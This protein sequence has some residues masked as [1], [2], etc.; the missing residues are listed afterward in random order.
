MHSCL[1]QG[2]VRHRRLE[3]V[4]NEFRYPITFLYLDLDEI[5]QVVARLPL[6]GC[7]RRCIAS[8]HRPD[9][10]GAS[11]VT[12]RE[13]VIGLLRAQL[14][15]VPEVGPI[16]LLTLWRSWGG[17]FSPV[18]FYYCFDHRDEA[19]VAIVAEVSNTPWGERHCYVLGEP[20]RL[21]GTRLAFENPKEFHVSPF[22]PVDLQYRWK[23][24]DPGSSLTLQLEVRREERCLLDATLT[25]R[26]RPLTRA[27]WLGTLLRYPWVPAYVLFA[28]Y[29]QAF[30]LW[31]K[32]APFFPHP[33]GIPLEE[34]PARTL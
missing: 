13:S 19:V 28:I 1:Y 12:L 7:G 30:R 26:Q 14:H 27:S 32:K 20:T 24:S 18:N 2:H 34:T 15:E 4:R 21:A 25:L 5:D 29:W 33:P 9:H 3:P 23:L 17:Y 31:F 22:L 8:F 16:R 6:L 11:N 10:L